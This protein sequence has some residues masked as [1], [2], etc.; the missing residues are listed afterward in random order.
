[1]PKK[2]QVVIRLLLSLL[3]IYGVFTETGKWTALTLFL[4]FIALECQNIINSR[5][6]N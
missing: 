3:L 1:M 6:G 4:V 2:L 5:Y